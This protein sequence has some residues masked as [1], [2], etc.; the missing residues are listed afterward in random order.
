[1]KGI[2][3][4]QSSKTEKRIKPMVFSST[5]FL[6]LFLPVALGGYYLIRLEYRNYWL[7]LV[8]LVFFSWQQPNYLWLILL[9]ITV[10]YIGALLANRLGGGE[11]LPLL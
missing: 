3:Y 7:L 11:K 2:L 6:F 10:N 1:M 5:L 4:G 8:S 9:N